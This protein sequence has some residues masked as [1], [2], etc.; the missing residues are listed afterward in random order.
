MVE[1]KEDQRWKHIKSGK[2]YFVSAIG[3]LKFSGGWHQSVSYYNAEDYDDTLYTRTAENFRE[4]FE[5]VY[6]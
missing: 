4:K 6:G 3:K 2:V 1:I 5:Y